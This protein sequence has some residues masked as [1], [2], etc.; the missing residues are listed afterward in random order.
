VFLQVPF[1]TRSHYSTNDERLPPYNQIG[2]LLWLASTQFNVGYAL[3]HMMAHLLKEGLFHAIF[4]QQK[5]KGLKP[6]VTV[7][8]FSADQT[9]SAVTLQPF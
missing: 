8:F 2:S 7:P 4:H 6:I 9:T 1:L 3:A 5:R